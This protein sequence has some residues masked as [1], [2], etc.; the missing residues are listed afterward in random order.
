MGVRSSAAR[1]TRSSRASPIPIARARRAQPGD[2]GRATPGAQ[3]FPGFRPSNEVDTSRTSVAAYANV[4]GDV[5]KWL[6]VGLAGRVE[7]YDDSGTPA[8]GKPALRTQ[9]HKRLV[10]RGAVSTGFRA[11]SLGRGNLS[12]VSTNFIP[13]GARASDPAGGGRHAPRHQSRRALVL[14]ATPLE[15]GAVDSRQRRRG[16]EPAEGPREDRTGCVSH[17]DR[18]SHRVVRQ[19][20]RRC[21]EGRAARAPR[22]QGR[23]PASSPTRSTPGRR[24][25]NVYDYQ[26]ALGERAGH[27]A[28]SA[29]VRKKPEHDDTWWRV[30]PTPPQLAGFEN[31]LFSRVPP[32]DL[33]FRRFTCG[34]PKNNLRLDGDYTRSPITL[35]GGPARTHAASTAASRPSTRFSRRSG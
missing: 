9:P 15:A 5:L 11:P 20:H 21:P 17:R 4:E 30:R 29:V 18:R 22:R 35:T 13:G 27:V 10:L 32:N 25:S 3:V 14:G 7:H 28:L 8:D 24:G 34:Q 31:T 6:R 33:E 26:R 12:A 23:A 1:T 19:L 16:L 2:G